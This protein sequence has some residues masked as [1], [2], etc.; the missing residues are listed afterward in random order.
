MN[1]RMNPTLTPTEHKLAEEI[2]DAWSV[3]GLAETA[4][5]RRAKVAARTALALLEPGWRDIEEYHKTALFN[6]PEFCSFFFEPVKSGRQ[7]LPAMVSHEPIRGLREA[8][9]YLPLPDAPGT[10]SGERDG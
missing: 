4:I 10:K 5:E 7:T 9:A 1:D 8:V 6:R 3:S 2:C